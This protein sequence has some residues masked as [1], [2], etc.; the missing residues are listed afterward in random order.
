M[1]HG[2]ASSPSCSTSHPPL[3]VATTTTLKGPGPALLPWL[4]HHHAM[5]F[6][7]S[8]L[9]WDDPDDPDQSLLSH[10][11]CAECVVSVRVD[12]AVR[13]EWRALPSY[14]VL[15]DHLDVV[16][17]RQRLNAEL[18]M[19]R[20]AALDVQWLLHLDAD[21]S[22]H[23]PFASVIDVLRDAL[24]AA[25][26]DDGS[27]DAAADADGLDA[28]VGQ[29]V[30]LNREAVPEQPEHEDWLSSVTLFRRH[31]FE[32]R[33]LDQ[34]SQQKAAALRRK[35]SSSQLRSPTGGY[36]L[37]D[38]GKS[39]VRVG[40]AEASADVHAFRLLPHA[41]VG[42]DG[43]G[44][45]S[46][47]GAE[48]ATRVQRNLS[49]ACVHHFPTTSFSSWRAKYAKGQ[50]GGRT[51]GSFPF[52]SAS[53]DVA[54]KGDEQARQFYRAVVLPHPR[55]VEE[56]LAIGSWLRVTPQAQRGGVDAPF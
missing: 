2:M 17:S 46:G 7:T 45:S 16:D 15:S 26:C 3:H 6:R 55:E 40:A 31:P 56:H 14:A 24:P 51:Q 43:G 30:L 28:A 19:R 48:Y 25:A 50:A 8:L 32:I 38:N 54:A 9:F 35:S 34:P 4:A 10:A 11:P 49:A 53:F 36:L 29:L 22:L 33:S 52:Y 23:S 13:D 42:T 47:G 37:Y 18:A 39:L 41:V 5:Q 12:A 27:C 21:E 1:H 44:G 20:A